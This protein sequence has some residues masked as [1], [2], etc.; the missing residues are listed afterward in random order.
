VAIAT[1]LQQGK[2]LSPAA[3]QHEN[4]R[5]AD[6]QGRLHVAQ[7]VTDQ[8]RTGQ[9]KAHFTGRAEQKPG[10][11]LATGAILVRT[12]RAVIDRIYAAAVTDDLSAH[13][14][15]DL[16]NI[17]SRGQSPADHRLIADQ[18]DGPVVR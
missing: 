13:L 3:G 14:P 12:V 16:L 7:G 18:D 5:T 11:R 4:R 2:L 6:R 17:L 9:V 1:F 10:T 8:I 15:V